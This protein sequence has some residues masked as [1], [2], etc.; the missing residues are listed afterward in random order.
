MLEARIPSVKQ[1]LRA[2]QKHLGYPTVNAFADAHG[3]ERNRLSGWLNGYNLPPVPQMVALLNRQ[4][5]RGLTLDWIYLGVADQ[6]PLAL[7]IRLQALADAV[8][9]PAGVQVEPAASPAASMPA[10]QRVSHK[11]A[12]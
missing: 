3:W 1:R 8:P 7:A 11:A 2:I 6:V 12:T 10:D 4:E 5:L 9:E